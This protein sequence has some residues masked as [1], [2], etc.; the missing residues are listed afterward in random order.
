MKVEVI[1]RYALS[2]PEATEEPHFNFTSF[3]IGG[4]IF[5]TVPPDEE[6][7]HV[8]VA[9]R[10]RD[11][12]LERYP[13]FVEKLSWGSKVVGLRVSLSLAL[14]NVVTELLRQAWL[15]KAPKRLVAKVASKK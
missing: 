3:R 11:A 15:R 10:D 2:L 1:R 14:P 13:G 7:V 9:D 8:F 4:K 12:A 6:H 5:A